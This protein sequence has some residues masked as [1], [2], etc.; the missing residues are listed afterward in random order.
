M[1][2]NLKKKRILEKMFYLYIQNILEFIGRF[3]LE[4]AIEKKDVIIMII[5]LKRNPINIHRFH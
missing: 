5:S 1:G 4:K 3:H 2:L